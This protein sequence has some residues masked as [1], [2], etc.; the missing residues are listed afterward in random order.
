MKVATILLAVA[1]IGLGGLCW[2]LKMRADAA[3]GE[4]ATLTQD[5]EQQRT[6]S[7]N[8]QDQIDSTLAERNQERERLNQKT[9][10]AEELRATI[11]T[12]RD[13][14]AAKN[15]AAKAAQD[16]A[17]QAA[18]ALETMKQERDKA[19][20]ELAQLRTDQ[21]GLVEQL[22]AAK[23]SA[24]K[25]A[26]EAKSAADEK[27]ALI[28]KVAEAQAANEELKKT[29][30]KLQGLAPKL[31]GK[32]IDGKVAEDLGEGKVLINA[33]SQKPDV[34]LEFSVFRNGEF[35]GRVK[36]YK[37]FEDYAGA[38]VTYV[39]PGKEIKVGDVV[40]TGFP[41]TPAEKK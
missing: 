20:Q 40:K 3:A 32:E 4:V 41:E 24:E 13:D 18:L 39:S 21:A 36:V 26:A 33:L 6:V 37:A 27:A 7:Q 29:V 25:L 11:K 5:L 12:L 38:R 17:D 8:R 1:A 14:A 16:K 31:A 34:D 15:D 9:A 28:A 23:A 2:F 10:E 22:T 35:I 19:V 30:E